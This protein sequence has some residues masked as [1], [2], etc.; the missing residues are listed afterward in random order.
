[1]KIGDKVVVVDTRPSWDGILCPLVVGQ[2]FVVL[3]FDPGATSPAIHLDGFPNPYKMNHPITGELS[4][5]PY[6][7]FRFRL[8]D[9]LAQDSIIHA[10][11]NQSIKER[12]I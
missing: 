12:T 2:R 3:G 8:I 11:V 9:Q 5:R 4:S 10:T 6:G 7:V 1:M